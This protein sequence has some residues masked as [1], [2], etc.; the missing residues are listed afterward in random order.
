MTEAFGAKQ[1]PRIRA[2][3]VGLVRREQLRLRQCFVLIN[4][5]VLDYGSLKA[6]TLRNQCSIGHY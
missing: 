2:R 1:P 3:I 6:V 5:L 4:L